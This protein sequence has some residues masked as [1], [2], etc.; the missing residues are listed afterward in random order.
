MA[1]TTLQPENVVHLS[2]VHKRRE[3]GVDEAWQRYVDASLK[4]K[5]TLALEDG[6]AAGKAFA[7]FVEL[8]D[9]KAS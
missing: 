4:A 8:F 9:R 2:V 6:I 1:R 5:A 7:D 3:I